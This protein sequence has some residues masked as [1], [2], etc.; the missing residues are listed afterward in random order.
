MNRANVAGGGRTT[1]KTEVAGQVEV[2]FNTDL[3]E[4]EVINIVQKNRR[5]IAQ[6]IN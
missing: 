1:V 3:F 4:S 6:I 2:K 5:K